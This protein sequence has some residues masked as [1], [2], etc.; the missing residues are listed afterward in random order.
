MFDQP[1]IVNLSRDAFNRRYASEL[2]GNSPALARR[3]G[4]SWRA[5]P[6]RDAKVPRLVCHAALG[7]K[8]TSSNRKFNVLRTG[9]ADVAA[10]PL[11][12]TQQQSSFKV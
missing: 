7:G 3:L 6:I 10:L 12:E 5:L 2:C 11:F 4:V 1:E 9:W 8:A